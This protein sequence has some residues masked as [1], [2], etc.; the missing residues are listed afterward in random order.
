MIDT[1]LRYIL[2]D[3]TRKLGEIARK[4]EKLARQLTETNRAL[5]ALAETDRSDEVPVVYDDQ[6]IGTAHV[7]PDEKGLYA[8]FTF[9]DHEWDP[10]DRL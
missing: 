1:E 6:R 7:K 5:R 9:T 4:Q 8:H 10:Q 3:I 2:Q